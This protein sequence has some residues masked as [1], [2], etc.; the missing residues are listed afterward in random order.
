VSATWQYSAEI[1]FEDS[2][3][4]TRVGTWSGFITDQVIA[5][6]VALDGSIIFTVNE[7]LDP[8]APQDVWRQ[9]GT[10][11]YAVSGDGIFK[12]GIKIYQWPLSDNLS[13]EALGDLG[14]SMDASYVGNVDTPYR[15]LNGCYVFIL[16]TLPD[17]SIDTF[18]PGIGFVEHSYTHN[19]TRQEEHFTLLSYVPGR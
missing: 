11:S 3:D 13:W 18:C 9:S 16:A 6:N 17:T 15:K 2:N 5:K 14:Y 7:N 19:G 1:S 4:N 10:Y 8:A 12:G